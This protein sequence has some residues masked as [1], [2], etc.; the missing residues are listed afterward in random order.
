MGKVQSLQ[1]APMSFTEFLLADAGDKLVSNLEAFDRIEPIP[2]AFFGPLCEKL[3][4]YFV[5]GG[6]P[7]S[8]IRQ[9]VVA[10]A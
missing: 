2:E 9:R 5:T 7:Q 1:L 8:A 4:M 6:M 10:D 3:K